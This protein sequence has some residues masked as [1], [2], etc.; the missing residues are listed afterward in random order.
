MEREI[1]VNRYSLLIVGCLHAGHFQRVTHR[2]A[3]GPGHSTTST[4][5][6]GDGKLTVTQKLHWRV[7]RGSTITAPNGNNQMLISGWADNG[8]FMPWHVICS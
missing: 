3:M 2:D 6:Q 1:N 7:H 5:T 8:V 4:C